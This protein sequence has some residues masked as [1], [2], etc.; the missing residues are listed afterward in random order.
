[1][2]IRSPAGETEDRRLR[3]YNIRKIPFEKQKEKSKFSNKEL[4]EIK[5][6]PVFKKL[7][8]QRKRASR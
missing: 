8:R 6:R 7:K 2:V 5:S 3:W 4:C 1:M